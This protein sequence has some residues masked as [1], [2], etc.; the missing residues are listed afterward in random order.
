[1]DLTSEWQDGGVT[2]DGVDDERAW[3]AVCER[4]ARFDGRFVFA[5]TSTGIFCRP[6]CPA[7]R[8]RR[9][10]VR[11]FAA[12]GA[13]TAAGFRAC[14]RCR[15]SAP[16]AP[17]ATLVRRAL[18]ALDG[19]A[20]VAEAA[21]ALGVSREHLTR[22]LRDATGLGA[23]DHQRAARAATLRAR[24]RDGDDVTR[25]MHAA[26]YGSSSRLSDEAGAALGMTPGAFRRGGAG[27][28][29]RYAV[30]ACRYGRL[31][32]AVTARGLAAVLLGDDDAAVEAELARELPR[33]DRVRD[34]AGLAP[35]VS[36]VR[37][38]VDG[39]RRG[40]A[41]PLDVEATAWQRRV[42]AALADIPRGETRSYA[43]LARALGKPGAARAVGTACASNR[44]AVVIPCHRVVR[45]DG[46]MGG[47][48]WGEERKRRLLAD[49]AGISVNQDQK[50]SAGAQPSLPSVSRTLT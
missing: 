13:A 17:G 1:M 28:A 2:R 16:V 34:D 7:R 21:E 35:T 48:R 45:G 49:E 32:V 3:R 23:R 38:A 19:G 43:E 37:A 6:S 4:D 24:L 46:A 5:V 26:G 25:A 50:A 22:A 11:F 18:A 9:E 42:W 47:Y 14:R 33:A 27:E 40:P 12:A 29:L 10:R 44:V 30:V 20:S 41:L 15:P 8:P 39:G 36:A 31:L